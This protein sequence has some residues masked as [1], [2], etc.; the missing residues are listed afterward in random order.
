MERTPF[1]CCTLTDQLIFIILFVEYYF[2]YDVMKSDFLTL[3]DY[4]Y[5]LTMDGFSKLENEMEIH[6]CI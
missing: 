4:H 5:Q 2:F 6:Y 3:W 1:I